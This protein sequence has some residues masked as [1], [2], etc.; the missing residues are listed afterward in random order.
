LTESDSERVMKKVRGE[1]SEKD[2]EAALQRLGRLNLDE[3]L[4]TGAQALQ[5]ASETKSGLS[6][7]SNVLVDDRGTER[8]F[9]LTMCDRKSGSGFLLRILGRTTTLYMKLGIPKPE[10]G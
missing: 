4:A 9:Q 1:N 10:S 3:G 2:I 7:L 5:I 8:D 6:P